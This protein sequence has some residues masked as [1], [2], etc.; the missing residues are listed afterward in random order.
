MGRASLCTR[1]RIPPSLREHP[2]C[3]P[4]C[5]A[6]HAGG[7][8]SLLRNV[9]LRRRGNQSSRWKRSD[10]Q[11]SDPA[12][13]FIVQNGYCDAAV[14]DNVMRSA[15]YIRQF[16]MYSRY[17]FGRRRGFVG[18]AYMAP[19]AGAGLWFVYFGFRGGSSSES[20]DWP[21]YGNARGS[22]RETTAGPF[23]ME[24]EA[25]RRR[26]CLSRATKDVRHAPLIRERV[27]GFCHD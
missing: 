16:R 22:R 9:I 18:E 6:T 27:G 1:R 19:L 5:R 24:R 2:P 15:Y 17:L 8:A 3:A 11:K 12:R 20:D 13:C 4:L 7:P 14:L 21:S 26:E 25:V 10:M 23:F